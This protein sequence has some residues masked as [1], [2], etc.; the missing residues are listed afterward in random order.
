MP[1]GD[2]LRQWLSRKHPAF[3]PVRSAP[4]V[5]SRLIEIYFSILQRKTLAP[6]DLK[7]CSETS[8]SPCAL[9]PLLV[10]LPM[11]YIPR[12]GKH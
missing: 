9:N 2:R 12:F 8:S 3:L 6:N 5:P 4:A 10:P 7:S 1:A 11:L